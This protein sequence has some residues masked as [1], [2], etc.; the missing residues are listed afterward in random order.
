[1]ILVTLGTQDKPFSRLLKAVEKEIKE[2]NINEKVIAQAGFTKF[3]SRY[4]EVI[5]LVPINEFDKILEE[6]TLVITHGGV[7]S[8]LGSLRK[9]KKVIAVPRY[10]KYKE[11]TNDHQ[12]QIVEELSKQKYIIGCMDVND[13]GVSIQKSKDFIPRTYK[14]GNTK[15]IKLITEFIEEKK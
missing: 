7:G 15:M 3:T 12:V 8:I 6:A 13:I 9:G 1:M 10:S 14:A 2:G 5:D 11:H 4:M